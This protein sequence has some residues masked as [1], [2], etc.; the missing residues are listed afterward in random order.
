MRSDVPVQKLRPPLTFCEHAHLSSIVILSPQGEGS[1]MRSGRQLQQLPLACGERVTSLCLPKEK[2]PRERPPRTA[3]AAR[4]RART[5]G[6]DDGPSLARHRRGVIPHAAPAG[7]VAVPAP[8]RGVS[9]RARTMPVASC[10]T[11]N[12][13]RPETPPQG[14][15]VPMIRRRQPIVGL[16]ILS[17]QGEGPF[18]RSGEPLPKPRPPLA[19]GER[20]HLSSVVILSPQG[21]GPFMRSGASLPKPRLPLAGGEHEHLSSVVLPSP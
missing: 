16:V 9:E 2:S 21:E 6:A 5:A 20:A 17:P 3:P 14:G 19:C 11:P 15:L 13:T 4:V 18:M 8:P 1:F 7:L 10:A 12:A